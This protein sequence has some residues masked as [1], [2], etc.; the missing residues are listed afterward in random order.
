M[1]GLSHFF[2]SP[3]RDTGP[4]LL[5]STVFLLA[6]WFGVVG[7]SPVCLPGSVILAREKEG[8]VLFVWVQLTFISFNLLYVRFLRYYK[9]NVESL[10]LPG[11]MT[12]Q[13]GDSSQRNA[14]TSWEMIST[15]PLVHYQGNL[16]SKLLWKSIFFLFPLLN[17]DM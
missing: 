14:E 10:T 3:S 8:M 1:R 7:S 17:L 9:I 16:L 15:Q 13:F 5:V 2:F 6:C 4:L 12:I 11:P